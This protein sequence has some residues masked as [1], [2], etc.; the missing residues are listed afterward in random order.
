MNMANCNPEKQEE[1]QEQAAL[2]SMLID[3]ISTM[4][5]ANN[6]CLACIRAKLIC[7]LTTQICINGDNGDISQENLELLIKS[8]RD[9]I[10]ATATAVK[11]TSNSMQ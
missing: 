1:A 11:M 6:M 8:M 2:L 4:A 9:T 7:V 5:I 3:M 10:N